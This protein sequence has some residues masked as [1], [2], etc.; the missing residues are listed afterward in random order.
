MKNFL[1][2]NL[3]KSKIY[4]AYLFKDFSIKGKLYLRGLPQLLFILLALFPIVFITGKYVEVVFQI[5][6][7]LLLRYKFPKTYHASTTLKCTLLTLTIGYIAIPQILP[8]SQSLFS[9]ILISFAIAYLSWLAQEMIDRGMI[10]K[11]YD[12]YAEWRRMDE[13]TLNEYLVKK[14]L[15]ARQRAVVVAMRQGI[16]GERQIDYMLSLG[17]DYSPSTQDRE[18]KQIKKKLNLN[19]IKDL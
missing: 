14:G 5:M 1:K 15:S 12:N 6:A 9:V 7:L 18:Y 4:F 8:F 11:K 2:K 17:F 10:I 19:N 13:N 3:R 16:V